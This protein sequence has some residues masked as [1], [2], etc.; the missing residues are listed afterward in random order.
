MK[1]FY[2]GGYAYLGRVFYDKR[3]KHNCGLIFFM[4]QKYFQ[5]LKFLHTKNG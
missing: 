1:V 3:G 2:S 5:K 4:K